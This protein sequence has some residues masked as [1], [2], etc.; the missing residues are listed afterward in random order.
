MSVLNICTYPDPVLKQK[1]V[2]VEKIDESLKGLI[3]DMLDTMYQAPGIGLAANQVGKPVRL[4]VFDVT[5]KD[6]P[7]NPRVLINPE[8][9]CS[10]GSQSH[11]EGCLSV[12]DFYTEV[13][14]CSKV[15]V[16]GLDAQGQPVEVEGEGLLAVVLQHEIDHLDG[17]LM[18]DR[19]SALKRALYKKRR[20]KQLKSQ[21]E[22][23]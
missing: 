11:E 6:Q 2:P 21:D 13:K 9:V 10:E 22:T 12:P 20:Q 18:L 14:R 4:I 15:T 8:I 17:F 5:P 3:E 7:R 23:G 19:I 1:A 16:R